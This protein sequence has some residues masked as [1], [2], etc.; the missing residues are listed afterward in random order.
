MVY[1]LVFAIVEI[2]V[3]LGQIVIVALASEG[4]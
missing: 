3:V 1:S 4:L 2:V